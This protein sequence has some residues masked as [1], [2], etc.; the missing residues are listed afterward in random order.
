MRAHEVGRDYQVLIDPSL[1]LVRNDKAAYHAAVCLHN[2][3]GD[4]KE[5]VEIGENGSYVY[6][7]GKDALVKRHAG[8]GAGEE[9]GSLPRLEEGSL[10]NPFD[11]IIAV[12]TRIK[13]N[14]PKVLVLVDEGDVPCGQLEAR[15]ILVKTRHDGEGVGCTGAKGAKCCRISLGDKAGGRGAGGSG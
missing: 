2:I 13:E 11:M 12:I 5:G 14:H 3:M 9:Q 1:P 15:T 6:V 4:D 7:E 8:E 10:E